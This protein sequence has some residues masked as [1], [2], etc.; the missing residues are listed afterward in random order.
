MTEVNTSLEQDSV[1]TMPTVQAMEKNVNVIEQQQAGPSVGPEKER[2]PQFPGNS[3]HYLFRHWVDD[4]QDAAEDNGWTAAITLRKAKKAAQGELRDRIAKLQVPVT[5]TI[6]DVCVMITETKLGDDQY[7]KATSDLAKHHCQRPGEQLDS[8]YDRTCSQW[9]L[10]F[11]GWESNELGVTMATRLFLIGLKDRNL[12]SLAR[13]H[14]TTWR[15]LEEVYRFLKA[16]AGIEDTFDYVANGHGNGNGGGNGV[17][18]M[19][20]DAV[21]MKK[22][23]CYNCNRY[24]HFRRDCKVKRQMNSANNS[25]GQMRNYNSA[26]GSYNTARGNGNSRGRGSYVS[27]RPA[28]GAQRGGRGGRGGFGGN[29]RYRRR[30]QE[31]SEE[32]PS[33]GD[34][35]EEEYIVYE[36][37]EDYE[38][39]DGNDYELENT[40]EGKTHKT[41]FQGALAK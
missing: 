5:A 20:V 4:I 3:K 24:G 23:K 39:Y 7:M 22:V 6:K 14:K 31:L 38:Q 21:D 8:F 32:N 13:T 25:R 15:S 18:P 11:P 17:T 35:N 9:K 16:R 37:Q 28:S 40:Y 29:V 1:D 36:D 26:R 27:R 41:D 10:A 19:E 30:V 33:N 34:E 12:Y 2:I